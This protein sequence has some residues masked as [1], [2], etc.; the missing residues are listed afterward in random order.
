MALASITFA[1]QAL[2]S[3]TDGTVNLGA[4]ISLHT[5]TTGTTG[6]AEATGGGYARQAMTWNAASSGTRTN[7]GTASFTTTG[8]TPN[9][10][11]GT[12]SAATGGIFGIGLPLSSSVTAVTITVAAGALT[13]SAS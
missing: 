6:A 10:H 9:T 8:A 7:S 11:I 4:F 1:N 5:A 3:L 13:L 12:N 2:D